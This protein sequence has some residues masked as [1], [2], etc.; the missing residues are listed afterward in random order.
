MEKFKLRA[1]IREVK[2][3]AVRDL[4]RRGEIPAVLYGRKKENLNL[5]I[6]TRDFHKLYREA[7]TS[8]IIALDIAEKGIKN[9]L[10]QDIAFDPVTDAPIH[11]DFYEVSMSEKITTAVP[12]KF[13][14]DSAAV[15]EL[16]GTLVTN[17][18]EVEVECLPADLP[19]E[20]EADLSLL[21]DFDTALHVSDIK[22]GAGVEIKDDPD[23]VIAIVEPPRSEEELAELEEPIEAPDLS[24]EEA[25]ETEPAS[26]PE[27]ES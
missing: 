19:H 5:S 16:G 21:K 27:T 22:V 2:G 25:A 15:I 9:V 3:K 18:S 23:E 1:I 13:V 4:R 10:V 11:L 24:V 14:G 12:L 17:K 6:A 7:G 8:S 20:I 26:E